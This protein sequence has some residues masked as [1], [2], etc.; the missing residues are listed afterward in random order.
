M[1]YVLVACDDQEDSLYLDQGFHAQPGHISVICM[2]VGK[3]LL[4]FTFNRPVD[5]LPFFNYP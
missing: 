4:D 2:D 3:K 1:H 5:E